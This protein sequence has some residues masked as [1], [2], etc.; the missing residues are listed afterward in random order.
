MMLGTPYIWWNFKKAIHLDN[1]FP[2]ILFDGRSQET[3]WDV[4]QNHEEFVE[5]SQPVNSYRP[6]RISESS[7]KVENTFKLSSYESFA[8]L[9]A[10]WL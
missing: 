6:G 7:S 2:P 3:T 5:N 10:G 9:S 8:S 4:F 1:V